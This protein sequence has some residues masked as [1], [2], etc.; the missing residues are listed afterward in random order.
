[1]NGGRFVGLGMIVGQTFP[2][3]TGTALSYGTSSTSVTSA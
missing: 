3:A 2:A 1:M